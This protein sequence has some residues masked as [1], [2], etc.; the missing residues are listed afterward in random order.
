[1][2]IILIT[3]AFIGTILFFTLEIQE[4]VKISN[5]EIF[6]ENAPKQY[7][8]PVESE[9][10][11][12]YVNEGD[13]LNI[14]DTILVLTNETLSAELMTIHKDQQLKETNLYVLKEKIKNLD[15]KINI[16]NRE[17]N[18]LDGNLSTQRKSL[19]YEFKSLAQQLS[20]LKLQLEKSKTRIEKDLKL[21]QK[22]AVSEREFR[23]KEK[24]F[25]D[26]NNNY[27]SLENKYFQIENRLQNHSQTKASSIENQNLSIITSKSLRL[28]MQNQIA[29]ENSALQQLDQRKKSIKKE[30]SKL[31]VISEM[32]GYAS[33][34]FNLKKDL[35]FVSKGQALLTVNPKNESDF[36]AN[37]QINEKEMKDIKVGQKAKIKVEAYNHYQHGFLEA[38][39][40]QITKNESN[41]FYVTADIL[42]EKN[43][44]LKSG[45]KVSG[46]VILNKIKLSKYVANMLFRKI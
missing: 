3:S 20:S 22:G 11:K 26:E 17:L 10:Q 27:L 45:Y 37:L 28:D 43:F 4:T 42:N 14:G 23:V 29:Q 5:G 24:A 44:D 46:E 39:I 33:S 15:D 7:L 12:I 6:S 25:Q 18:Y 16:Q 1:M 30:L 9:I 2:F 21:F 13:P 41:V 36:Y 34:I 19:E 8:A 35:N 38:E 32:D 31:V 40:I